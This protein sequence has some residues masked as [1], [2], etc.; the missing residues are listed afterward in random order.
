MHDL[1]RLWAALKAL[2]VKPEVPAVS[3]LSTVAPFRAAKREERMRTL[4]CIPRSTPPRSRARTERVAHQGISTSGRT[5]PQTRI[6][7]LGSSSP[8]PAISALRLIPL[9][10]RACVGESAWHARC[11]TVRACGVCV[12]V[13]ARARA[14]LCLRVCVGGAR[15]CMRT[16]ALASLCSFVCSVGVCVLRTTQRACMRARFVHVDVRLGVACL[17]AS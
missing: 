16:R 7:P 2:A 5:A 1:H 6:S 13:C 11:A 8:S 4:C 9:H 17:R 10:E 3:V 12:C 14:Y 15:A